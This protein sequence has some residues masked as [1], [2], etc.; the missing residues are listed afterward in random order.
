MLMTTVFVKTHRYGD[1]MILYLAR[2]MITRRR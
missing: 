1:G 2:D